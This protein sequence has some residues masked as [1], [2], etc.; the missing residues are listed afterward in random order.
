MMMVFVRLGDLD[1]SAFPMPVASVFL[2]A[3]ACLAIAP[4]ALKLFTTAV[5]RD[6]DPSQGAN[7]FDG[8]LI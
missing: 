5:F 7:F 8:A 2:L 6:V 3:G 4:T 1:G